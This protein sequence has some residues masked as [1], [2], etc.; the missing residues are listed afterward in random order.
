MPVSAKK[1]KSPDAARK[2]GKRR[3]PELPESG[4]Y[5]D[6]FKPMLATLVDAPF[7]DPDW[8]FEI[9]WDGFRAIAEI[10]A[11]KIRLYSR[12]GLSFVSKFPLII[13]EL[14]KI[15]DEAIIDGEI[16]VLNEEGKADFQKLQFYEGNKHL[17]L[18]YY[19]FDIVKLNGKDLTRLTLTERKAI[20]KK[21]LPQSEVIRYCDHIEEDGT[22]MFNQ[23]REH[24]LE[25][26]IAKRASSVYSPGAR[27]KEWQKIKHHQSREAIICGYTAPRG[28]RNHFGALILG[29]YDNNKLKYIGHTGTGF[30]EK[31]LATLHAKMQKLVTA[32]APFATRVKVNAGVTWLKPKLVCQVNYSEVTNDGMLRHP[33]YMGLRNDKT[34]KEVQRKNETPVALHEPVKEVE[35]DEAATQI[36]VDKRTVAVSNLSK[37]Y[38]PDDGY[39]KGDLIEYYLGVAKYIVPHLQ[40]RPMSLKRNP[41]GILDEGFYHKDAGGSAPSWVKKKLVHSESANKNINYLLCNDAASLIYIANLGC[42]EM[43]PWNSRI[44]KLDHPDYLVIDLDPSD[45]NTFE[46]VIETALTVHELLESLAI[47]NFCKTSGASGLHI[48]IPMGAK[49]EY[50]E[51]KDFGKMIASRVVHQLPEFTTI[52]RSLAKRGPKIY[53]DFLQNRQGQTLASVYSVRPKP[54]ATVSAPLEWKEVKKGLHPGMFN[55]KNML[56]RISKKGDLFEGVHTKGIDLRAA[57]RRLNP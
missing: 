33:V 20:L 48:Y 12:N 28:A 25:G 21:M 3:V 41:N 19:V 13:E 5:S 22:G 1:K 57:I 10:T 17:Q 15:P 18:V 51:V 6:F 49:Y 24:N 52:E 34:E 46:Q 9:K 14:A 35:V 47:P 2:S 56:E 39:T 32:K 45:N 8:V 42:I 40:N 29:E 7:D 4:K 53:V 16:I 44:N 36:V 31:T 38:W 50:D 54:G 43:N 27:S 23:I 30:N 26:I 55:I 11:A 37:L